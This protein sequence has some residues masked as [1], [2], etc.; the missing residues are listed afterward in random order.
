MALKFR[1]LITFRV[2]YILRKN[3][4]TAHQK[5]KKTKKIKRKKRK[6]I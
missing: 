1:L 6:E 3:K 2:D 5:K 4:Y